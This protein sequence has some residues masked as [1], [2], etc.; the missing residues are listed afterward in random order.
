MTG[1]FSLHAEVDGAVVVR[2]EEGDDKRQ[3]GEGGEDGAE[4]EPEDAAAA[5]PHHAATAEAAQQPAQQSEGVRGQKGEAAAAVSWRIVAVVTVRILL[6][7]YFF[8]ERENDRH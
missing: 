3:E 6:E 8:R 1:P 5:G 4:P 7:E 2:G